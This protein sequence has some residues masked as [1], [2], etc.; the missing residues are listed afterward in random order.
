MIPPSFIADLNDWI[1]NSEKHAACHDEGETQLPLVLPVLTA[2]ERYAQGISLYTILLIPACWHRC[3]STSPTAWHA[4][5]QVVELNSLF[6]AHSL[7]EHERTGIGELL[8]NTS[9]VTWCWVRVKTNLG[10]WKWRNTRTSCDNPTIK[11][12]SVK[13]NFVKVHVVNLQNHELIVLRMQ[14]Q[15]GC[16]LLYKRWLKSK[17]SRMWKV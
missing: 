7:V 13:S 3:A 15:N 16:R 17:Y 5:T 11:H 10:K 9:A 4:A 2:L 8:E 6:S 14:E 12:N 1:W